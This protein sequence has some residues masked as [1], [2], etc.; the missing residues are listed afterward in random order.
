MNPWQEHLA[1]VVEYETMLGDGDPNGMATLVLHL[2]PDV[3]VPVTHTKFI[4]DFILDS[5]L[6][7][8]SFVERCE[9]RTS[10]IPPSAITKVTKSLLCDLRIN[11][12]LSPKHMRL[13]SGGLQPG[14]YIFRFMLVSAN[15]HG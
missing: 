13:W 9:F 4:E 5:G 15:Y 11:P 8:T 6:S 12:T 1:A 2:A 14:G 3:T 7:S 10:L